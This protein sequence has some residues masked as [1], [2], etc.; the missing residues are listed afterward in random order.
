MNHFLLLEKANFNLNKKGGR[1]DIFIYF[2]EFLID[3]CVIIKSI[4]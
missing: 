2:G 4:R 1:L 3:V